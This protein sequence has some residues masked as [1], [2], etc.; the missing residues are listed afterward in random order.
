ML[1]SYLLCFYL[2]YLK[3][4]R[5]LAHLYVLFSIFYFM[6]FGC[7]NTTQI[8]PGQLSEDALNKR[9]IEGLKMG[10]NRGTEGGVLV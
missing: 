10:F 1:L 8:G 9:K 3:F 7:G 4:R 5:L 6:F 2:L